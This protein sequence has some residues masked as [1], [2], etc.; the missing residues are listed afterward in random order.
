MVALKAAVLGTGT[1]FKLAARTRLVR[2]SIPPSLLPA[3]GIHRLLDREDA[4]NLAPTTSKADMVVV[5]EVFGSAT[6]PAGLTTDT[7]AAVDLIDTELVTLK[8]WL[9]D[10]LITNRLGGLCAPLEYRGADTAL[11]LGLAQGTEMV[12]FKT[13]I[14][15][16]K[17]DSRSP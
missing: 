8:A 15:T 2:Q 10:T 3:C 4:K 6:A 12:A 16:N 13:T 5:L 17:T 7:L 9:K 1:P 14:V 11:M